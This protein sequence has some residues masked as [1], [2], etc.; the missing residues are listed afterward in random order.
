MKTNEF[1]CPICLECN[2]QEYAQ[3]KFR[4]YYICTGCGLI[5]VPRTE[6]IS[7]ED[8]RVRYEHHQNESEDPAYFD[9]LSKIARECEPYLKMGD[10]GLDFGCGPSPLLAHIF[11]ARGFVT[12]SYDLYFHPHLSYK[13]KTYDFIILSEVIEHLRNP[14]EVMKELGK[15]LNDNGKIFIK[16][17]FY[18]EK[19]LFH[20]WFYKRDLTHIQFFNRGS[21]ENLAKILQMG[22]YGEIGSDLFFM[23]RI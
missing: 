4:S 18:P 16:T 2:T 5:F 6:L 10:E 22:F 11:S 7:T 21:S 12:N 9:Y 17:K 3:D 20:N 15:L 14:L 1:N 13:T 23:K 8:E 19:E